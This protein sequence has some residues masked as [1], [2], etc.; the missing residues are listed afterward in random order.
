MDRLDIFAVQGTLKSL[1]QH[2]SSKVTTVE[3]GNK[4]IRNT[5]VKRLKEEK[6][7][8]TS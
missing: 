1:L 8:I 6:Q 2:H 3:E 5:V 7:V 4:S